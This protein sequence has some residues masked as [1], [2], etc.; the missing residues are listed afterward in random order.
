MKDQIVKCF[1]CAED[2]E[3]GIKISRVEEVL[4]GDLDILFK[5]LKK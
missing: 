3:T 4:N 5:K 2:H 1:Y